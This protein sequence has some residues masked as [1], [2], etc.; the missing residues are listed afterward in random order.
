MSLR[1]NAAKIAIGRR[2][3]RLRS[4]NLGDSKSVG[5]GVF[6]LRIDT[7]QGYRIYFK[8]EGERIVVLLAG[9]NKSTQSA[10]IKMAHKMAKEEWRVDTD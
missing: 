5:G 2:I 4:G 6:E 1:D 9:G 7:G 10:D 3:E 8:N